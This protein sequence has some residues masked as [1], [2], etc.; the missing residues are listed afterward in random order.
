MTLQVITTTG[1]ILK[2]KLKFDTEYE[3]QD[4]YLR[5]STCK[6]KEHMMLQGR[7]WQ[8]YHYLVISPMKFKLKKKDHRS[9]TKILQPIQV[10]TV[11][12]NCSGKDEWIPCYLAKPIIRPW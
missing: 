10:S 3:Q 1:L 8:E 7:R 12:L 4:N 2:H 11:D 6:Q 5:M 9:Q